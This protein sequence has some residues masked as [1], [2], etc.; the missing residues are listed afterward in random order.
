MTGI[1]NGELSMTYIRQVSCVGGALLLLNCVLS[2][3]ALAGESQLPPSGPDTAGQVPGVNISQDKP[4]LTE[5]GSVHEGRTAQL[6]EQTTYIQI[7]DALRKQ[8]ALEQQLL[9]MLSTRNG[10]ENDTPPLNPGMTQQQTGIVPETEAEKQAYASGVGLWRD[11]SNSLSMQQSLGIHLDSG[12]VLAGLT[13]SANG[14]TLRLSETE[15]SAAMNDLKQDYIER[16]SAARKRQVEMGEAYLVQF[17]TEKGV[18]SDSGSWYRIFS[19]GNGKKLSANDRVQ[20]K[21]S[22]TLPDGSVF[23]S[24]DGNQGEARQVKVG[25]L[26]PAVSVGLQKVAPGGHLKI[27]VPPDKG[28]G[29]AGLPPAIPGGATLIFDIQVQSVIGDKGAV[30]SAN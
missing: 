3:T 1:I 4:P 25:A 19:E 5:D 27:V 16:D 6:P 2:V 26:L 13:D 15:M 14:K 30:S 20:I 29:D 9:Q 12:L 7:L 8:L 28:Y 24:D 22:G 10:G 11:I 23:D 21:I 18:F 17:R